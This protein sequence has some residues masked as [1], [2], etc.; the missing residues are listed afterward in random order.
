VSQ[1]TLR[2][3]EAGK[4]TPRPEHLKQVIE[5][6]LQ[7]QVFPIGHEE[8]EMRRVWKK[9]QQN[10]QLDEAWLKA[11]LAA[12]LRQQGR[13]LPFPGVEIRA[14]EAAAP[15]A[16]PQVDWG[17]ALE[18]PTWYGREQELEVLSSWIL[19]EHCRVVSVL[20]MG[21][22][23]K[24]A[25]AVRTMTH[26][27]E[28]FEVVLFRSLRNALPCEA[29]LADCLQ[30]LSSQSGP[31]PVL[32]EQRTTLLLDHL[33]RRRTLLVL[34]N[35]ES[36]LDEGEQAGRF[37]AGFEGYEH[38]VSRIAQ[39]AHQSCLLLTSREQAAPVRL[40]ESRYAFMRSLRLSGL[41]LTAGERLLS[42]KEVRGTQQEKARLIEQYA[43][44]PLALRIVSETI[45]ERFAGQIA[46]FLAAGSVVFGSMSDLLEEHWI[47]LSRLE[48]T[49][50]RWLAIM[51][52][53]VTLEELRAIMV[54]FQAQGVL[55]ALDR[56]SRRALIERGQRAGSFTLQSVVLAYVTAALV[57][58]VTEEIQHSQLD[59]LIQHGLELAQ[60]K[61]Y[62]RQAQERV[63]LRP[64]LAHVQSQEQVLRLLEQV[65]TWVQDAQGYGPANLIALLRLMRGHLCGLDLSELLIR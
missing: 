13:I 52:E 11:L 56:L 51:R 54:E 18:I 53:P 42:E 25:L 47:R 1:Q 21:G 20:G 45:A 3:W 23:G 4:R 9:A 29:L 33:A 46:Q 6:A 27:A 26:L 43:G 37:R 17:E 55:N 39:G 40:L 65:R 24:S 15:A 38:I 59:V 5:L 58:T 12:R 62:L 60:S 14:Q 10:V 31:L 30:I 61:D 49:L 57:S 28:Q 50:L 48:H 64:I 35:L 34:D 19:Q 36:L 41:D 22:I 16:G 2:N 7:G 32:L 44:N 8:E 63:L